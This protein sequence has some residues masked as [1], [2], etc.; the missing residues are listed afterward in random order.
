MWNF[1][2]DRMVWIKGQNTDEY[3]DRDVNCLHQKYSSLKLDV[4]NEKEKGIMLNRFQILKVFALLLF[5]EKGV[6]PAYGVNTSTVQNLDFGTIVQISDNVTLIMDTNGNVVEINGGIHSGITTKGE[7]LMEAVDSNYTS[8]RVESLSI[9]AGS[10]LVFPTG[11]A[12]EIINPTISTSTPDFSIARRWGG[13]GYLPDSYD[14]YV[15]GALKISGGYCPEG[16]HIINLVPN[17]T[18]K[19]CTTITNCYCIDNPASIENKSGVLTASVTIK[20]SLSVQETQSLDF[21]TIIA[22]P[23]PQSIKMSTN[24][25]RSGGV[26]SQY[27]ATGQQ[28]IFKV[29]GNPGYQV[30]I[31]VPASAVIQNSNGTSLNVTLNTDSTTLMLNESGGTGTAT[32]S[33]GGT[34]EVNANQDQGDY[35]GTY[36][37]GV[38]Y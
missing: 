6:F 1:Q 24:G 11:C 18:E 17:W 20:N 23:Q 12:I 28:G 37:V 7:G 2:I 32:F 4:V 19:H 10:P 29:T 5:L 15:G 36:T 9:E 34:L 22:M 25:Q 14:V 3:V 21:G 35:Q 38:N 33:V 30:N 16:T 26:S 27:D 8:E 31:N 13:C